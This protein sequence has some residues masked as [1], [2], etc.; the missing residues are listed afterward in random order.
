MAVPVPPLSS[1]DAPPES[2]RIDSDEVHV[3]RAVLDLPPSHLHVLE[4]TLA[5]D[6]RARAQQFRF[7]KDRAHFV[8]ARGIL[9][10]IL[11]RYLFREPRALSFSYSQYGKPALV[12]EAGSG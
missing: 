12:E 6:E 7:P 1:W 9:R 10:A 3:W 2:L 4:Q 11:G 8:A 5:E